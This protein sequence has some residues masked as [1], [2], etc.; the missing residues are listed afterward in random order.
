[1]KKKD[2]SILGDKREIAEK[3]VKIMTE[4]SISIKDL[5]ELTTKFIEAIHNFIKEKNLK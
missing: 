3:I 5:P 1:M 2:I 4:M